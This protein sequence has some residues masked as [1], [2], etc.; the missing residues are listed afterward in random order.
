MPALIIILCILLAIVLL[1]L[2]RVR[3]AISFKDGHIR[4]LLKILFLRFDLFSDKKTRI[5]KS[6]FKIKRFRRRR[7]KVLREYRDKK[8]PKNTARSEVKK[9]QTSPIQLIDTLKLML[10]DAVNLFEKHHRIEK[11]YV[12]I[13]VGGNDAAQVAILYGLT[14]QALQYFVTFAEYT[15]NLDKTKRKKADVK[16]DFKDGKW[17]ARVDIEGSVRVIHLIKI[18]LAAM[19]GYF[20]HKEKI[21]PQK[22]VENN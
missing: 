7:D 1:M 15:S 14:V 18:G 21:K 9:K 3:L 2:M 20:R 11:F 5:K 4:V 8:P 19:I 6:D 13:T 12:E 10:T 16:A 17:D 22:A